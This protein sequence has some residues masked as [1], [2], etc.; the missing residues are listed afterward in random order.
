[1]DKTKTM[2]MQLD[3][4]LRSLPPRERLAL[5]HRLLM[6]LSHE[7]KFC[8]PP[9]LPHAQCAW[10]PFRHLNQLVILLS[11]WIVSGGVGIS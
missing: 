10:C 11:Q 8:V 1:M 3:K 7:R 4:V 5:V 6:V 9:S 2:E